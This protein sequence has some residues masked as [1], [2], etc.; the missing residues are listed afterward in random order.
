[1][2]REEPLFELADNTEEKILRRIPIETLICTVI[3]AVADL[4][5]FDYLIVDV[6]IARG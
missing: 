5:L 1:M 3:A 2:T 4:F 6:S